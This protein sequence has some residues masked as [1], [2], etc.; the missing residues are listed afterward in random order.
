MELNDLFSIT[1]LLFNLNHLKMKEFSFE[2]IRLYDHP[3]L[4]GIMIFKANRTISKYPRIL[5]E[6]VAYF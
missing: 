1:D 4:F 3:L 5:P 6:D 2:F